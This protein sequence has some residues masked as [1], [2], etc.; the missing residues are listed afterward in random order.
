MTEKMQIMNGYKQK[1]FEDF[2]SKYVGEAVH[3]GDFTYGIPNV[4]SWGEGTK[5]EIGKFCSIADN[6]VIMLGGNHRTDWVTTYPFNCL[7]SDF[8]YIKGHPSSKG[9][10]IIGND[11]WL[12]SNTVILSGVTIGDGAVIAANT[13]VVKDVPPYSVV[14]GNPGKVIKKRF[15]KKIISQLESMKWWDWD[16]EHIYNVI[17]FLQSNQVD[18]VIQYYR[19]QVN[20]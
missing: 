14:G 1:I 4:R 16:Y 18:Q 5:C 7:F 11:V 17:P 2:Q 19:K 15:S 8:S 13:V 10:V 9:D 6:V 20:C 12:A 3:V